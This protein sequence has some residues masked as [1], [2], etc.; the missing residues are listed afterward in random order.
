MHRA[1]V[2]VDRIDI[3]RV[4]GCSRAKQEQQSVLTD[5]V[6]IAELMGDVG[7]L[8]VVKDHESSMRAT[9]RKV[10]GSGSR[11]GFCGGGSCEQHT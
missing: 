11:F 9:S 3:G 7:L 5:Y 10:R 2:L 4:M 8:V 6:L 1:A